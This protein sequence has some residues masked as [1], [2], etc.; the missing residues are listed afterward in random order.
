MEQRNFSRRSV[1]RTGAVLGVSATMAGTAGCV[2]NIPFVGGGGGAGGYVEWL[3]A[4]GELGDKDHYQFLTVFPQQLLEHEDE[5]GDN[6]VD[7]VKA[8]AGDSIFSEYD[9]DPED[10]RQVILSEAGF[11]GI[12][13]FDRERLV[14]D[15]EDADFDDSD[16]YNGY[17][18]YT[19][20]GSADHAIAL[21]DSH[22]LM[23]IGGSGYDNERA[24]ETMIDTKNGEE[25][26][27]YDE[28]ESMQ[29]LANHLGDGGLHAGS[30]FEETSS[31]RGT[32]EID[33]IVGTGSGYDV[34]GEETIIV[35]AYVFETEDDAVVEEVRD[36]HE[37]SS[38]ETIY[39]GNDD[40]DVSKSGRTVTITG[41]GDT[42]DI[43]DSF[44]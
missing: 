34:R 43:F 32:A 37:A 33:N 22:V 14:D 29:L 4:P 23:G 17:T 28:V 26:R 31:E 27:Y 20:D 42:S 11:I 6:G 10:F 21:D 9:L 3:H 44:G 2:S 36:Y 19:S 24:L 1:L 16:E 15:I 13:D 7:A 30:T 40:P 38:S 35:D 39:D 12:G 5:I 8:A 25:D 41:R 18:F